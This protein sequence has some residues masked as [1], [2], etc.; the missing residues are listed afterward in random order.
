MREKDILRKI[1]EEEG[2]CDWVNTHTKACN[3]C[4]L[5]RLKRKENGD[6]FSCIEALNTDNMSIH[7]ANNRYKDIAMRVLEELEVE[8]ILLGNTDAEDNS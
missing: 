8:D 2:S 4:P 5:S 7:D 1:I 3:I 6:F